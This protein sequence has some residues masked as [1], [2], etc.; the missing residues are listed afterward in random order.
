MAKKKGPKQRL[1]EPVLIRLK[2]HPDE[3]CN[4][5]ELR[6]ENVYE[7]W[8]KAKA[9]RGLANAAALMLLAQELNCMGGALRLIKGSKSPSKIV[10]WIKGK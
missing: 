3:R 6:S 1:A 2:V 7:L 9:E 8:V 5:I 10:A 4:R